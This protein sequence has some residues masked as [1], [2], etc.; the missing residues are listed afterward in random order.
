MAPRLTLARTGAAILGAAVA[1]SLGVAL[2]ASADT[3]P[4]GTLVGGAESG[5]TSTVNMIGPDGKSSSEP[6][7][8]MGLKMSDGS[9]SYMYCVQLTVEEGK[10]GHPMQQQPWDKF[11]ADARSTFDA[12]GADGVAND[13]KINWLLHQSYPI[14]DLNTLDAT[15][16]KAEGLKTAPT[17]TVPE[18]VAATQAAIWSYSESSEGLDTKNNPSDVVDLY[19]YLT[20]TANTG[21]ALATQTSVDISIT[22]GSQAGHVGDKIGPFTVNSNVDSLKV[23]AKLPKGVTVTDADGNPL[24]LSAVKDGTQ[25]YFD[26]PAGTAKGTASLSVSGELQTGELFIGQETA[27]AATLKT[28]AVTPDCPP[29][30][31]QSSI[32]AEN[33]GGSKTASASWD[34]VAPPSSSV[35]PTTTT[36]PPTSSQ[37][38][39]IPPPAPTTTTAPQVQTTS[40]SLPFTGVSLGLPIGIAVVLIGAGGVFLFLQR[41]RK[42]V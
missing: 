8:L 33:T 30:V 2:P 4:T 18:A 17:L 27:Q 10:P 3:A 14:V 23:T 32:I 26:V 35:P 19:N 36:A 6:T 12:K 37:P 31:V 40:Q 13:L 34:V 20:S 25:F 38:V 1:L 16:A 9:V 24:D 29:A 22:P 21:L 15:V 42:R 11:P 5:T 41:R 39:V 7:G 28:N